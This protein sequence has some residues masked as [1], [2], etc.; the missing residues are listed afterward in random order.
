MYKEA[1]KLGGGHY[2]TK[3]LKIEHKQLLVVMYEEAGK[4]GEI[5]VDEV[6][7]N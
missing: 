7:N 3:S 6:I 4:L 5:L 1:G 2:S